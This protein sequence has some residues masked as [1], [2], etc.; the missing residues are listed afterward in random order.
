LRTLRSRF[1]RLRAFTPLVVAGVFALAATTA[2]GLEPS[3][4]RPIP[5]SDFGPVVIDAD[6]SGAPSLLEAAE[7]AAATPWAAPSF[8]LRPLADPATPTDPPARP[9]PPLPSPHRIV[10][11]LAPPKPAHSIAG[12]ASWY[13][14]SDDPSGPTSICHYAYPDGPGFDAYAAAGPGLRAAIGSGWRNT[15]VLICGRTCVRVQL[16]DWCKCTGGSVGVQKLIDLYYDVYV[17]TGSKITIG[18]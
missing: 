2:A 7:S 8:E 10:V 17:R 14:N 18:W 5:G 9:Q 16:I 11:Q 15:V 4:D 1:P 6:G 13:C 3:P 12:L